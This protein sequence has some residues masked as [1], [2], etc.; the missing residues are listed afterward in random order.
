MQKNNINTVTI[1]P[2]ADAKITVAGDN[3]IIRQAEKTPTTSPIIKLNKSEYYVK[4]DLEYYQLQAIA[5][6]QADKSQIMPYYPDDVRHFSTDNT[7]RLDNIDNLKRTFSKF[8]NLVRCNFSGGANE[9]WITLTYGEH[10]DDLKQVYSD[11]NRLRNALNKQFGHL[12]YIMVKEFTGSGSVHMHVLLK[13]SYE[14]LKARGES[15]L[16]IDNSEL[17][18]LWKHGFTSVKRL[19]DGDRPADYLSAYLT[20]MPLDEARSMPEDERLKIVTKTDAKGKE[21]QIVKGLRLYYYPKGI[22]YYH[23]SRDVKQPIEATDRTD[24][25]AEFTTIENQVWES[26]KHISIDRGEDK[27]PYTNIFKTKIY[28]VADVEK[29]NNVMAMKLAKVQRQEQ[30]KIVGRWSDD[31]P[32]QNAPDSMREQESRQLND[33]RTIVTT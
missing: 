18:R 1:E 22:K 2:Y 15:S 5:R 29:L 12:T 8:R 6:W 21:K 31:R 32:P 16:Y 4:S 28:Q 27:E 10:Q 25:L 9:L 24:D 13:Q 26:E 17:E 7:K 3:L 33:K 11:W 20:D 30:S 19:K 23:C 14:Q